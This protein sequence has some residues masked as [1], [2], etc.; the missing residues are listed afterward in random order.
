MTGDT[1]LRRITTSTHEL[2]HTSFM[3]VTEIFHSIQGES[4]FAGLPCVFVRLTGC[5][6]RCTWCDTA[7]AFFGGTEQSIKDLRKGPVVWVSLSRGDGRRTLGST[8]NPR[9]VGAIV[10]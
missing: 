2:A 5:P 6:L 4:T 7:Y 10:S 1:P 3:R 9:P 8:G